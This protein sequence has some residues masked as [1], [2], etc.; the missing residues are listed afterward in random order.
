MYDY[1]AY[2]NFP[3][4]IDYAC[5]SLCSCHLRYGRLEVVKYLVNETTADV[6]SKANN[7]MTPLDQARV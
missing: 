4:T 5:L 7:G 2:S 6:N 3:V 1:F